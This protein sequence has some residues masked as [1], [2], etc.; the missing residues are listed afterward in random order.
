MNQ[1]HNERNSQQIISCIAVI[2]IVTD[3]YSMLFAAVTRGYQALV[4]QDATN[5]ANGVRTKLGKPGSWEVFREPKACN[6]LKPIP[7]F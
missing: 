5:R 4:P 1:P 2:G 3:L 6:G 7:C